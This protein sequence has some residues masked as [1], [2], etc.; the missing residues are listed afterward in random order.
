[1]VGVQPKAVIVLDSPAESVEH[2]RR[3]LHDR[4]AAVADEVMV[5]FVDEVIDGRTVAEMDVIDDVQLR[6][7]VER[8]VHGGPVDVGFGPLNRLGE[9]LRRHVMIAFEQGGDDRPPGRRD[10]AAT[11]TQAEQDLLEA[12]IGHRVEPTDPSSGANSDR[13]TVARNGRAGIMHELS[14]CQAIADAA[15]GRADGRH[16]SRVTVRIGHLRQVV[17]DS[18]LFA[19]ELLTDNT[20]LAGSEL[21][22]E[23]VPA[24][25]EC[26][27]CGEQTTLDAPLMI[28]GSCD[29][30]DVR[31]VRGDELLLVSL[32]VTEPVT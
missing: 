8:S 32:D 22:I 20:T 14:L 31:V 28:C 16:V 5:F 6:E 15:D 9:C 3:Q 30:T 13:G 25:I 29:G 27:G 12:V 19:W 23:H 21:D 4:P 17:P 10:P 2:I 11:L 1:M 24:V 26:S 18:M 7:R